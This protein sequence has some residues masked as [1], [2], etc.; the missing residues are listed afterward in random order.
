MTLDGLANIG[1]FIGGIFVLVTLVYLAQQVRQNTKS[2]R[3][4]NYARVLDR[5]SMVQSRFAADAELNHIFLV[6]AEDPARLTRAE[7]TRFTWALYEMFGAGEFMYH[8]SLTQALPPIVWERWE[9]TIRWWISHPGMRAWYVAKPTPLTADFE[10]FLNN[11]IENDP[12]DP[13]V[14][15]RW[16]QFVAGE[17]LPA[18][19]VSRKAPKERDAPDVPGNGNEFVPDRH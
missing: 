17:G 1:E 6:G 8:Q 18:P 2:L 5:M 4:E 13:A 3:T 14:I 10:A 12:M 19:A 7:R 16:R 9:A 15:D 11:M